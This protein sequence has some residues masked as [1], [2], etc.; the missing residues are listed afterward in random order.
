M[1]EV[2]HRATDGPEVV[3]QDHGRTLRLDI[4]G[5]RAIAIG[6]VLAFHAGIPFFTGG[7]VGVDVFFVLSGFLITGLLAREVGRTG[8]VRL[9]TFW[10]RRARRLLP[11]SATVL[12]FSVFVS[13]AYLPFTQRPTFGGDIRAAAL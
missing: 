5:M 7:F 6:A 9:G 8:R 1:S 12:L 4:E 10:A 11:A 13:W 3:R 2:A